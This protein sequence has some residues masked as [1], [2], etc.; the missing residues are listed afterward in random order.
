MIRNEKE[1]YYFKFFILI[2]FLGW[3]FVKPIKKGD[4]KNVILLNNFITVRK[5]IDLNCNFINLNCS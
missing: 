5:N 3:V 1:I 2:Q 4:K